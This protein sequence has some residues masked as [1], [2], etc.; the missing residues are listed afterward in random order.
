MAHTISEKERNVLLK[1]LIHFKWDYL[2]SDV[3]VSTLCYDRNGH[4]CEWNVGVAT[5]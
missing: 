2:A 4:Q 3:Y 5:D 1:H